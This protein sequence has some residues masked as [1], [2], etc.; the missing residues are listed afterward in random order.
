MCTHSFIKWQSCSSRL[1]DEM[2][3][4]Q[5]KTNLSGGND[6]DCQRA[7]GAGDLRLQRLEALDHGDGVGQSLPCRE[8]RESRVTHTHTFVEGNKYNNQV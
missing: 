4:Y 6:D 7:V 8:S 3:R 5:P 2:Q 1:T